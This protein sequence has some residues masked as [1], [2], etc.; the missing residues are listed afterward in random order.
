M[1]DQ[2]WAEAFARDWVSAWN[3][4][5]LE[6]IFAHYADDFEM[7]SPLIAQRMGVANGTLKGK[8]AVRPYWEAGLA[9]QPPLHFDLIGV[10]VGVRDLAIHYTSVTRGVRVIERIEFDDRGLGARAT[11]LYGPAA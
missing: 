11:A 10:Y 3:A 5:D 1:I 7:T 6:R 2:D 8:A 9:A 4:H